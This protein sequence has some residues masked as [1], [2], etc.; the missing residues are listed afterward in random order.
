M[1]QMQPLAQKFSELLIA[2]SYMVCPRKSL[3]SLPVFFSSLLSHF[4]LAEVKKRLLSY[5]DF[6]GPIMVFP[7]KNVLRSGVLQRFHISHL[8]QL[9][10][11]F[12]V[13]MKGQ[14]EA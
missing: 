4:Q 1:V 12:T 6:V 13:I 2:G 11:T 14:R 10:P 5:M 9:C 3:L 7:L 8:C